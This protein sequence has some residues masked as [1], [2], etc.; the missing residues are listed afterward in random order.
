MEKCSV[1]QGKMRVEQAETPGGVS[2]RFF[3]CLKCGEEVLDR[4]QLHAVAQ[5]YHLNP[6]ES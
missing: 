5:Q 4:E 6:E 2:Y 3:K 1:C